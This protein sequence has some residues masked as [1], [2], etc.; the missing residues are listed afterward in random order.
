MQL[1]NTV[2]ST[3]EA[4]DEYFKETW[5]RVNP[6]SPMPFISDTKNEENEEGESDIG[7]FEDQV[8]H[9]GTLKIPLLTRWWHVN[10]C[11]TQVIRSLNSRKKNLANSTH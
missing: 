1:L 11:A 8:S 7:M 9:V 3:Q 2:W 6:N 5:V 10:T 4:L